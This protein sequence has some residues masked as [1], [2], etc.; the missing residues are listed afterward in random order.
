MI[1]F[2]IIVWPFLFVL[3]TIIQMGLF[4]M[5]QSA[6]DAGVN[7]E[8]V[9]LRNM[10][11]SAATPTLPTAAQLK[12]AV[13]NAAGGLVYDTGALAVEVRQLASLDASSVAITDGVVDFGTTTLD[14]PLA[15]RAQANVVAFAPGF[16]SL[17]TVTSSAVVRREGR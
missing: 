5:T 3:L 17:I 15:L 1:E 9:A 2:A 11:N 12:Q 10:F 14:T 8:A 16:G 7:G 6:L 13:V 4:Y